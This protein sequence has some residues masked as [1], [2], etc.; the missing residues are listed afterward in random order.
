M[1]FIPIDTGIN[2]TKKQFLWFSHKIFNKTKLIFKINVYIIIL[3]C[4]SSL[5]VHQTFRNGSQEPR[6]GK[7]EEKKCLVRNI[8]IPADS[9]HDRNQK[10]SHTSGGGGRIY[11]SRLWL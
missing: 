9:H 8:S 2:K 6:W 10:P 7:I 5:Y 11:P 3:I 1:K 4:F